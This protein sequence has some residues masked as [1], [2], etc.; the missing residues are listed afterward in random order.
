MTSALKRLSDRWGSARDY[1]NTVVE[2]KS[3]DWVETEL[4]VK[5]PDDYRDQVLDIG[6][7]RIRLVLLSAI[8]D[9]VLPLYDLWAL[10]TP[11]EIIVETEDWRHIGMPNDLVVFGRDSLGNKFCF[12]NKDIATSVPS[13]NVSFWDHD[14]QAT[15]VIAT[16]FTSL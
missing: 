9:N 11:E 15:T 12:S 3:L 14:F 2:A 1:P 6:L 10:L 13:A 8:V 5:L 7:P 4:N 16:S